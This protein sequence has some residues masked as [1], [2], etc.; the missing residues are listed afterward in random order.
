MAI[1][2]T[3]GEFDAVL[4][5]LLEGAA[6]GRQ[7]GRR[8]RGHGG[9]RARPA[10]GRGPRALA[11][12]LRRPPRRPRSPTNPA[13]ACSGSPASWPP[14]RSPPPGWPRRGS[15]PATSPP[16]SGSSSSRPT[17]CGT[18]PA[19]PGARSPTR[20]TAPAASRPARSR[21]ASSAERRGVELRR[22]RR[23]HRRSPA[24]GPRALPGGRPASRSPPTPPS[25]A[26]AP[27]P[28]ACSSSSAPS[29]DEPRTSVQDQ[30][31]CGGPPGCTDVEASGE[32]VLVVLVLGDPALDERA[33]GDHLLAVGP[34]GVEG[35]TGELA[36]EALALVGVADLG[37]DEVESVGRGA[38][39]GEPGDVAVDVDLVARLRRGC[40]RR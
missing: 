24:S 28:P 33:G 32:E 25:P 19:S 27:T 31:R 4:G 15:T 18:S 23:A 7:R 6:A 12:V 37:V 11:A 13:T 29:P 30:D 2:S 26:T 8:R 36:A 39:L 14:A 20:S 16:A 38:V 22:R 1:G 5:R 40:G 35:A 34:D 17:A 10:T 3:R 9:E 21:S